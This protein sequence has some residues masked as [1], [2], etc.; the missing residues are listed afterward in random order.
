M[1]SSGE[2]AD[3]GALSAGADGAVDQ[4]APVEASTLPGAGSAGCGAAGALL[5]C[6]HESS[7]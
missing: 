6:H 1:K 5:S 2:A 7:R 4:K 3:T